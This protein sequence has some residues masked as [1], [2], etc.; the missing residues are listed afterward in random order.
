ME[1]NMKKFVIS[2]FLFAMFLFSCAE[3]PVSQPQI[4]STGDDAA[5]NMQFVV[6]ED[7]IDDGDYTND[8]QDS[9]IQ[10]NTS[11]NINNYYFFPDKVFINSHLMAKEKGN[12]GKYKAKYHWKHM[13][14]NYFE[15]RVIGFH[16]NNYEIRIPTP[17]SLRINTIKY[18]DTLSIVDDVDDDYDNEIEFG[19]AFRHLSSPNIEVE[20]FANG[21]ANLEL[22][23]IADLEGKYKYTFKTNNTGKIV[24]SKYSLKNI[25]L[26]NLFYKLRITVNSEV[27]SDIKGMKALKKTKSSYTTTVFIK[28]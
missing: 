12:S 27:K 26:P 10:I 14:S 17:D 24:L 5:Q 18:L 16:H 13:N 20:L 25:I 2:S 8:D 4:P 23:N 15:W 3:A 6:E 19:Y 1:K 11:F 9:I 21:L 28:G 22:L 7:Y